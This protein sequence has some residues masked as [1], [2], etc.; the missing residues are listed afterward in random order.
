MIVVKK[1]TS[2]FEVQLI[3]ELSNSFLDLFGLY[4]KILF[5]IE[6]RFHTEYKD[7][8]SSSLLQVLAGKY[9]K[10]TDYSLTV[11]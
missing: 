5:V 2:K 3:A 11:Q 9:F 7:N 4:S 10:N 8:F 6:S 1:L